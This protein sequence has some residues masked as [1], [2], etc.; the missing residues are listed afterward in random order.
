MFPRLIDGKVYVPIVPSFV[1][2]VCIEGMRE[3]L[4]DL[5]AY[6]PNGENLL[7]W[8]RGARRQQRYMDCE[9]GGSLD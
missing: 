4:P 8:K 2:G 6:D 5:P 7:T 9:H 1:D 3:M